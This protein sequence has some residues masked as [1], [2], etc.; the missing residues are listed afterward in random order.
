[1]QRSQLTR[2]RIAAGLV[3]VVA[4]CVAA[5]SPE[6]PLADPAANPTPSQSAAAPAESGDWMAAAQR[7]IA[8]REYWA[9]ENGEGLQAPNRA[10]NL[11][12]SFEPTGVRVR[13]RTAAGSPTL[14][15]LRLAGIGRGAAL[16]PVDPGEVASDGA[17]VEI[18]RPGLLEWYENTPAGL[19]QGFT[20][21]DRPA[22]DGP[23]VLE[24]SVSGAE[25]SLAGDRVIFRSRS[26]RRLEYGHLA[27]F[28]A[29]GESVAAH[30]ALPDAERLQ[31]VTDDRAARYPLTIDPL[32]TATA[33]S[34][35]ESNQADAVLG[36]S[37]AG[38]GDVNGDGYADVIVGAH[39]YDAGAGPGEGAA[40]VFLGGASGIVVSGNPG[41]AASQIASGQ[42]GAALGFSVAGAGDVNG[43]GYAD[44]IVGAYDYDAGAG[45]GEGAA[46]VFLGSSSGVVA[47]GNPGNAAS[48]IESGLAGAQLGYSVDGAGDV[49]GDGYADV[50]VGSL[51]YDAGSNDEGAAFVFHGSASGIAGCTPGTP[52]RCDPADAEAQ[53]ESN[54]ADAQMGR[55]VAGAGDVNGDGYADVI[56]GAYF[57]DDGENDEGS[58]FVFLGSASGIVG[59][60]PATAATR[61]QSNQIGG[62]MG[63]GVASAGDVNG[64]GYA[65]V[66]VG[67]SHYSDGESNEG[68]AFIFLGSAAGIAHGDPS[69]P[70]VAHL[71]SNQANTDLGEDVAGAGDV[72]GDGYADVIVGARIYDFEGAAFVFYGSA[73]GID[74]GDPGNADAVLGL[75]QAN[76]GLGRS[77][78]GAGDV[79][80]DGY[81]DVIVGA[82][83]FDGGQNG[84]GAAFVYLGGASGIADGNPTT[85][86]A[87]LESNQIDGWIDSSVA[88]AG[89]VNGD[90]YADV[91]VGAPVYDAGETGEGAAFVFLGSSSGIANGNP[92]TAAAQLESDQVG[93]QLGVSVAGAGDVNGD[94]YADVIVGANSYN[95]GENT[96]GAAFVFHGSAS[97]IVASGNP[98]NADT[99]LESNQANAWLGASVAG[100]GDVNGDGY[101][102]VIV[103]AASYD[104]GE[105]ANE[106]AAFVFL[107][108]S[109]GIADGSP[110]TAAAQFE[111]DQAN[112]ALGASVAGAGDVNGDGYADVIVGAHNYDAGE[113]A[114]EG[115]AFVFLGSASGI[116]S[117]NPA[118]A[119]AQLESDQPSALLGWSVAGAG[120]VNGDGYADAIVAARLYDAGQNNEGAAFVF[121]GSA[122]GIVAS[123]NPTNA[124]AQLESNQV[125]GGLGFSVAGAGDVNGDGYADVIVGAKL[126]DAGQGFAEGAAF[127]FLGSAT[128]IADGNPATAAA[129]FE[130]DQANAELGQSVAGAGDVNGDG[131]A[132]VIVG[133]SR[134][135]AP[136]S[137][138]GAA[139]VFLGPIGNGDGD[140]RPV[141]VQQLR[142]GGDLTPV[143]P[144]G[145]VHDGDDFQVRMTATHPLGRG[146]VKGEVETCPAGVP[147]GDPGCIHE[148]SQSWIDVTATPG[149][150]V[151]TGTFAGL[152]PDSSYRWRARVLYAPFGVTQPGITAPP[153]PAHSPWRR[154]LG[155][156][157]EA[158][159]RTGAPGDADA[160]GLLDVVET[161]TGTYV[162]ENN[163]GTDPLNPD[164]DGD[165]LTDGDEVNTF[166]TDPND[167]DHDND[168]YCDGPNDPGGGECPSGVSDNCPAVSNAGQTNTDALP[169]GDDC[170]CGDANNTGA[171]DAADLQ[172][173]REHLMGRNPAGFVAKRCNVIGPSDGGTSDC[174]VADSFILQRFLSGSPVSVENAC[175][176]Y[177]GL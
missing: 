95:A 172:I 57:Y 75:A 140:S 2:G 99:Q 154:Y 173:V 131:Y 45:S 93:G 125:S 59:T 92:A 69:S 7:H 139:F 102:D 39:E 105:G 18:R 78:A 152:S 23:L 170:Q 101:A 36:R 106:G 77:V 34:Q 16:A 128:G 30:F 12:T 150:V 174:D 66:I 10:H 53:L 29:A 147:F 169:A 160:D 64:D 130:P 70:G 72:N 28:D 40:F 162:D 133:A 177:L 114:G 63:H 90:G 60:D 113:G 76:A 91:I 50:I 112:A 142:G 144:W 62:L 37:V 98:T 158:D 65:D 129:Q 164:S 26:G 167:S 121:H 100:A 123:G 17:R 25:V 153:N 27:V 175:D 141:V 38:A 32:L 42:A 148:I 119:A 67:S 88:G 55:R 109:S 54:Q 84:E 56:V 116:T 122:S 82:D 146:R 4:A 14:V 159:F 83:Q 163:T 79:N 166:G 43:D 120:D 48:Q 115:A 134:Y 58:A 15:E 111:S 33:D 20:L 149:G 74:D 73:S 135:D 19:E 117:G 138:E 68:A 51:L 11:R 127:V 107:G 71:Q 126:Y 85:A 21:E 132:D 136:T 1:M 9:S 13:D 97:G 108:S 171:V 155:Q 6:A 24:L 52:P 5:S 118:T 35:L 156:A 157:F 47:S 143:Q 86:H 46:F 96:E 151:L 168:G 81:A 41:N 61:L 176:A 89:D 80:G 94:G 87:Q 8:E 104:A 161:D 165:G 3:W 103:G 49:N 137:R 44:V 124:D 31:L 145:L 110:A 22:G